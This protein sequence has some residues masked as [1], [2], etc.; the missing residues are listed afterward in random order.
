[1]KRF[2]LSSLKI[3][4]LP[5]IFCFVISSC[6]LLFNNNAGGWLGISPSDANINTG[7]TF[8]LTAVI[9]GQNGETSDVTGSAIWNTSDGSIATVGKGRVMAVTSGKT[10]WIGAEA[11]G[12][13]ATARISIQDAGPAAGAAWF[14][15]ATIAKAPMTSFDVQIHVNTGGKKLKLFQIEIDYDP[16]LI[17]ISSAAIIPTGYE[18]NTLSPGSNYVVISADYPA[19]SEPT[20]NDL[21]L[22]DLIMMTHTMAGQCILSIPTLYLILKDDAGNV[23]GMPTAYGCTVTVGS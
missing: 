17:M 6:G 21:Y 18:N 14:Y 13:S 1:M 4:V 2:K 5:A 9:H 20:G 22:A 12:L 7:Q 19:G 11:D 10:V 23:I 16:A 8:Q 15:P 3:K